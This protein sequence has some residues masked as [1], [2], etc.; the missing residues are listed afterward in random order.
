M[1]K[2]AGNDSAKKAAAVNTI[3]ES[4]SKI[5]KAEDFTRQQD[6]IRRSAELLKIDESGL[7]TLVN[8]LIREKI[9]KQ[10][11]DSRTVNEPAK[12]NDFVANDET[13]AL[14]NKDELHERALVR[15]LIEFGH[16]PWTEEENVATYL[17]REMGEWDINLQPPLQKLVITYQTLLQNNIEPNAKYFLY[18]EDAEISAAAV[19]LQDIK[20]EVSSR[21][22]EAPHEIKVPTREEIY[23]NEI[24]SV[25]LYF[26]LRKL[27]E[28]I[29]NNQKDLQEPQNAEKL[30]LLLQT[31]QELKSMEM[32]LT[33]ALGTVILK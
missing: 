31:H 8:K 1:L 28:M 17:F 32:K 6:Y 24:Y 20:E 12:E 19:A 21:W 14:F 23:L 10:E 26:K 33:E 29:E 18:H 27:K 15:C 9:A 2:D 13:L 22:K 16:L 4:I 7:H 30:L 5:N 25:S 11:K 3:A